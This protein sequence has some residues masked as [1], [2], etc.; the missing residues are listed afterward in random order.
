MTRKE[1]N[2][3]NTTKTQDFY[4]YVLGFYGKGGIYEMNA[5]HNVI[6]VACCL[7]AQRKDIPFDGDTVDREHVR[8]ILERFGYRSDKYNWRSENNKNFPSIPQQ[9]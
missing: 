6:Y 2:K 1:V 5:P 8:E 4:N 7:V 9:A 3:M